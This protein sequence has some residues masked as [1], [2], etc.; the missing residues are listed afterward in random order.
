MHRDPR[1]W[2]SWLRSCCGS[3]SLPPPRADDEMRDVVGRLL[4]PTALLRV[5]PLMSIA[6]MALPAHEQYLAD[7]AQVMPPPG[8][9]AVAALLVE[10]RGER[11]V[12][13]GTDPSLHPLVVPLT[14]SS[15]GEVTGLLRWP[16]ASGG[17]TKLPLVKTDGRQLLQL[18]PCAEVRRLRKAV[19]RL[20]PGCA[21]HPRFAPRRSTTC[22]ASSCS[23]LR[24]RSTTRRT[25][26]RSRR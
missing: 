3:C 26:R 8:L 9:S 11:L 6:P 18:A 21:H 24:T 17:G 1:I 20:L 22:T 12:E 2:V 19:L 4:S 16:G 5:V 7:V 25:R 23:P 14:T 13:P 15:E 10:A